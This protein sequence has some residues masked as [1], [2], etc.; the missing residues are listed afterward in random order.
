MPPTPRPDSLAV[1]VLLTALVAFGPLSTDLYLPSLP[2]LVT[3]FGTDI[4]TVQL[5]LSVF[6][7]GFAVSQLVYGPVSDRFGRRPALLGGITIYLVASA[8]CAL[9]N[10]IGGLIVARFFQALGACCGPVVARAVVRDVFGRDRAATV[11]AYMAMAMTLAPAIGPVL[12]GVIT[13]LIGW[14]G[15]FLLLTVFAAGI[16]AATQVLLGET[17]THRDENALK[18]GRLVAN[19]VLLLRDRAFL[20]QMLTVAF[21]Y[22]GIFSFISGSSFVLIGRLHLTPAQY[23][24]SFGVVVLGYTLGSFF[25]GRMSQ[26]M[27]GPWMI[28][29]GTAVSLAGGLLGVALALAGAL[30]L[31]AIVAPVFLFMVG[32]GLTLPNAMAAAVGPYPMMAGL[33]SSLVGFTQMAVAALVGAAVGHLQTGTPLPMMGAIGLVALGAALSHRMMARRR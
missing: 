8:A 25:A 12:G 10:D 4:A 33:A 21:A 9:T 26:R 32:A 23:G 18:P 17:N 27:G 24:A 3:V 20:G 31:V 22:S 15:N 7:A 14:R 16:L 29:T 5:T 30:H 2:T 1:R 28:R 11:L 6:L 13:E 19:Y